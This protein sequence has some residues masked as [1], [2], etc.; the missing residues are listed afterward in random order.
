[1]LAEDPDLYLDI[2]RLN[3]H[4]DEV[5]RAAR[6]ALEHLSALVA[7]GDRESFRATLTQARQALGDELA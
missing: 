7:D 6:E 3:P 5:H 1:V 2:Q 4:R